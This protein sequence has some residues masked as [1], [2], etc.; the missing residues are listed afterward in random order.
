VVDTTRRKQYDDLTCH[1]DDS[2]QNVPHFPRNPYRKSENMESRKPTNEYRYRC[3]V[4][5]K[6]KIINSETR[7]LRYLDHKIDVDPDDIC[8]KDI[9]TAYSE[10]RIKKNAG[11]LEVRV[12]DENAV[13][14]ERD[15][16]LGDARSAL[17]KCEKAIEAAGYIV[18][19]PFERKR[20]NDQF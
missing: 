6:F 1:S 2:L 18:P 8:G 14:L 13:S 4:L 10:P 3:V 12:Y 5:E 20:S 9:R 17:D 19:P 11:L 15:T 7:M 16:L